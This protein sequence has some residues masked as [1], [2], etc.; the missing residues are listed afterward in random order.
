MAASR[1]KPSVY[2]NRGDEEVLAE[3][4]REGLGRGDGLED[5]H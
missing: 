4:Y 3:R 5:A 1:L 2:V